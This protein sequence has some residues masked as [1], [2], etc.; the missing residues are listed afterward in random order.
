MSTLTK[1]TA[2]DILQ[3]ISDLRGEA[4]L[5][6]DASRIRAI[7]RAVG[8]FSTRRF[9][10]VYHL[11]DQTITSTGVGDYEIGDSTHPYRNKGLSELFIGGTSETNRC[12]I[13]DQKDFRSLYNRNNAETMVYEWYDTTND[14]W[15]IHISPDTS[16]DTITYSFYFQ[17]PAVTTTSSPVYTPDPDI[18]ARRALAYMYEGEDEDKYVTQ[19]Q[20]SE[21]MAKSWDEIEDT[22]NVNQTYSMTP[23]ST[24]GIGSY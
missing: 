16:G 4:T 2:N 12:N 9:W 19:F 23:P 13:V 3:I 15:M 11:N 5:N 10:N 22:P 1:Y 8:D 14:K 20:L 21:Q 24:Y 17:A 18:I 6:S 7:D